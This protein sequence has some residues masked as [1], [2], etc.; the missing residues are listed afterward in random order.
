MKDN[1]KLFNEWA[2]SYDDA[3]KE[4][5][6]NN[7]YPFAGY[8]NIQEIIYQN[9]TKRKNT[10]VLEM[11]IGTGRMTFSLYEDGYEITGVDSSIEMIK[12]ATE[13]MPKNKYIHK[14]FNDALEDLKGQKFDVIIFTY[15]IHHINPQRQEYLLV[16]LSEYLSMGGE[17][18]VGDVMTKTNDE[19]LNISKS[20]KSIWDEDEF[21]PTFENYFKQGIIDLYELD[22]LT[23]T[24][25]SGVMKLKLK[26]MKG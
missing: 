1:T 15:S 17:I 21:Y 3:V 10:T 4:S 16:K 5:D 20:N 13:I 24:F 12:M 7:T 18:I 8:S 14:N 19:M 22:Y 6:R 2:S 26:E 23:V 25:C 9:I 11:G